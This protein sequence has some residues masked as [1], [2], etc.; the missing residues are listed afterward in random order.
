MNDVQGQ[1]KEKI[2]LSLVQPPGDLTIG[3]YLGAIQNFV[4]MQDDFRCYFA[5]AD[6]HAITVQQVPAD[7]RRRSKEVLAYYIAC[8][9]DPQKSTLFVQSHIP[10]HA[11]LTWVLS[12]MSYLGQLSRMT[13]FKDKSQKN[14]ENINAALLTYPVLMA[15]DIL[16]YQADYVPVGEDQKQ[17]LEL[18]RDLAERF[19]NRYSPTFTVPEPYIQKETARIMSL[20]EP[21]KK[22]SKSDEDVNSFILIKDDPETIRRKI[23]RAVTDSEANFAYR[24]EQPGLMNLI[25]IYGAYAKVS[26]EEVV[27]RFQNASYADFKASLADLIVQ[28][29]SPIRERFLEILND[30]DYLPSIYE[31]GDR[32]AQQTARK[33]LSKVYRKVGF[34]Q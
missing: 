21:N 32:V 1:E 31:E 14:E 22:M 33:T 15:A 29:M 6:L 17:H 7:L 18:T 27:A 28:E 12:S 30:K 3:N 25:N 4:K 5:V 10:E 11:E 2:V 26:P 34:L 24:E 20:K 9:L 19:N 23:A 8:G 13:Q 16:L